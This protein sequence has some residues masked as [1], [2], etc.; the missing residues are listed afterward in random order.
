M[1]SFGIIIYSLITVS[2]CAQNPLGF[3]FDSNQTMA[4]VDFIKESNLI[5]L[6]INING[7]GPYNFILDTGSESGMIFDRAI[8]GEDNLSNAREIPIR[9]KDGLD[10]LEL[11]VADGIQIDFPG[12]KGNEQSLL[13][14]KENKLDIRNVIGIEAHGVL[15]S[16]LFNR[17]VVEVDYENGKLRLYEPN[18]LDIPKGYKRQRI[19]V[20]NF[21]PYIRTEIKQ[22]GNRPVEVNLLV[23]SGVSSAMFLDYEKHDFIDLPEKVV[24]HKLGSSLVGDLEGSLGRIS[25]IKIAKGLKFRSVVSSFP[26]NWEIEK[27][28]ENAHHKFTRHGTLGSDILSRFNVF[29]DYFNEQIYFKPNEKYKKPFSFNRV[30]FTFAAG[31]RDLSEYYITEI[32]DGSPAQSSGLQSGDKI[33]SIDGKPTYFY[34]FSDINSIIKGSV[35]KKLTIIV[36]RDNQLIKKT[37]KLKKLI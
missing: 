32:I 18:S 12:I 2:L 26:V 22:R 24:E 35:G 6:P 37:I 21:R 19:F 31:G 23:D 1:R 20:D 25:K 5:V 16:E 4:E 29:L 28:I 27:N 8:V 13:V 17:F 34:S 15:G 3:D 9:T 14:F 33:I 10:T 30:G 7:Q 36:Q 11:L